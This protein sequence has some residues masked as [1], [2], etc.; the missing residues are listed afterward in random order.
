MENAINAF[1]AAATEAEIRAAYDAM[2]E[3]SD[4]PEGSEADDVDNTL[5]LRGLASLSQRLE[6]SA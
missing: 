3:W 2:L 4:A 6:A 5:A 1:I